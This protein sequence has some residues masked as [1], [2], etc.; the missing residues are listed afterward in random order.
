MRCP[1]PTVLQIKFN[2]LGQ[3]QRAAPVDGVGLPPHVG[4]PGI[5]A[6]LATAAG[7][8]FATE[9]PSDFSA[10][11]ADVDIGDAAIRAGGRQ[12]GF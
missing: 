6:G 7:L 2:P 8:F 3:G 9:S 4:P 1:H 11:G 12:E 10:R 5:G